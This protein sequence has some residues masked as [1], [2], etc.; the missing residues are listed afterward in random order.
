MLEQ[1]TPYT[2]GKLKRRAFQQ[3][4]EHAS[5]IRGYGDTAPRSPKTTNQEFPE[6]PGANPHDPREGVLQRMPKHMYGG[7]SP[8]GGEKLLRIPF[9]LA[10][11]LLIRVTNCKLDWILRAS[12]DVRAW[13][14]SCPA[15]G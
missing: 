15:S 1:G 10:G 12:T 7:L 14:I 13:I 5:R 3:A 2:V 6:C 8:S 9:E 4:K 11:K